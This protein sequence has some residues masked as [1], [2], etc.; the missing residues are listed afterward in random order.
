MRDLIEHN[1]TRTVLLL[2]VLCGL[3]GG[4]GSE[5]QG[6]LRGQLLFQDRPLAQAQVEVYLRAEKDRSV[7]PFAVGST[8]ADG[9]FAVSL[10]PG[11]YFLIGKQRG[12]DASGR[13]RMLMAESPGNPHRVEAGG[14]RV[15]PFNLH[16]MGREGALVADADTGVSGQ[17]VYAGQGA[18]RTFVYVYSEEAGGLMGPS[19]GEA[20]QADDAGRFSIDLPAGRYFLV[21]R[22]RAGGSRSGGLSPGDLN[23]IYPQ[24][25]V[26]VVRGQRQALATFPLAAIDAEVQAERQ[27]AGTFTPT[28]TALTGQ[29]VD[30]DG[31]PVDG[32]YVF[33]YRDSR[34]VGK[35][36]YISAP[37]D[38]DGRFQLYLGSGGTYFIG[39]RSAYGG[40]LE[41]GEWVGTYDG[42]ADHSIQ[43]TAGQVRSLGS[44]TVREVW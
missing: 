16:E 40:P 20:V 44:M 38:A 25:P 28:D 19:Y 5:E 29:A 34:M 12:E 3:L 21:A 35:P 36:V 37:S 32:V 6:T 14:S 39:A 8:D 18:A 17:V 15:A 23:G 1:L 30:A 27:S 9:R 43:V 4:C 11:Q 41:P 7:Q 13:M 42:Q 24:N 22:K 26:T 10:P 33:A 31:R 2:I